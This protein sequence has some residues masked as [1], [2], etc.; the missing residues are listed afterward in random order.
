MTDILTREKFT[1]EVKKLLG[2]PPGTCVCPKCGSRHLMAMH[3]IAGG[4]GIGPYILCMNCSSVL[5]KCIDEDAA[6]ECLEAHIARELEK[7]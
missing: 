3:G 5:F 1:E 6:G 4:G 7:Q 2:G